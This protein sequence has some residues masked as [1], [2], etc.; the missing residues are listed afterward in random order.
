MKGR[1]GYDIR[2]RR[3]REIEALVQDLG[4]AETDDYPRHLVLWAQ[5]LPENA[6]R[7]IG[8]LRNA[9]R[10]MPR[11]HRRRGA[12]HHRESPKHVAP[13]DPRWLGPGARSHLRK[14]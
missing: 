2:R 13:A 9:S 8:I 12:R 7:M 3:R 6:D 1:G 10:R 5:A 4:P 11:N 14:T